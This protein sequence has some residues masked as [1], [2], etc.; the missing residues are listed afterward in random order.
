MTTRDDDVLTELRAELDVTPGPGFESRVMR[1]VLQVV[2]SPAA[3]DCQRWAASALMM[4][5]LCSVSDRQRRSAIVT[6]AADGVP[7]RRR[8]VHAELPQAGPTGSIVNVSRSQQSADVECRR[9]WCGRQARLQ[10]LVEA[11]RPESSWR[12]LVGTAPRLVSSAGADRSV[13]IPQM[14]TRPL[15]EELSQNE[16]R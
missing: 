7:R 13:I 2:D 14:T 4:V 16:W 1:R 3:V 12:R 11:A 9:C 8:V 5:L 6:D 15:S 10:T